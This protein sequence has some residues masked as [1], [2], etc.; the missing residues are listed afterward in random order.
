MFSIVWRR[1][2]SSHP[3]VPAAPAIMISPLGA[4]ARRAQK[5]PAISHRKR[6]QPSLRRMSGSAVHR[7]SA[8][9]RNELVSAQQLIAVV[10]LA[11]ARNSRPEPIGI[12][13]R[14]RIDDMN[15][16]GIWDCYSCQNVSNRIQRS[17]AFV[18]GNFEDSCRWINRQYMARTPLLFQRP[19]YRDAP[20]APAQVDACTAESRRHATSSFPPSA[21]GSGVTCER[22]TQFVQE[23]PRQAPPPQAW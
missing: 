5:A 17:K 12:G 22:H 10:L 7:H 4:V 18:N 9:N 2:F 21:A 16:R 3:T 19:P 6:Q 1:A 23:R 15:G 14:L 11:S 13:E 20:S 8:R